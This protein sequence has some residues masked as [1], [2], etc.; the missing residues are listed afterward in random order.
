MTDSSEPGPESHP[1]PASVEEVLAD[2]AEAAKQATEA[3]NK[4]AGRDMVA[5]T[6]VGVGLLAVAGACLFWFPWGFAA[7]VALIVVGAQVEFGRVLNQIRGTRIAVVPLGVGT[8]VLA[9]GT[10]GLHQYA[11][12][13]PG[14]FMVAT[15]GLTALVIL[16][17]R[18]LQ[19]LP[20]Y[21]LDV[22]SSLFLLLYTALTLAFILILVSPQGALK[23]VA[24]V[25][26]VTGSDTGGMLGVLFRKRHPFAQR[27]SPKKSW[28]GVGGSYTVASIAVVLVTVFALQAPW[29][30]GL[31]L[32]LV[33]VTSAIVGDLVES[34]IK[35]DL[36]IKDMGTVLPGHG[37]IMDRFDSYMFAAVPA[38]LAL[39]ALFPHG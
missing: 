32:A 17:V 7:F 10:Y 29:W 30:K 15:V 33:V 27:I 23:V 3:V 20:G 1:H 38:W 35:R 4:K 21:V 8:V 18:L 28:E 2:F 14:L 9:L 6:A 31:I 22:A 16:G 13:P 39:V 12:V 34:V 25:L 5:A 26:G 19:P 24:V 11:L 36:G 37:G